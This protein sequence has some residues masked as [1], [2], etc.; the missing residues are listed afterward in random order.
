LYL[1]NKNYLIWIDA[2][3]KWPEVVE[4]SKMNSVH[5][6]EKL[7]EI[8]GRFGL[9]NKIISDNGPQ[10]RASAFI[11][12][13]KQNGIV[14]YTS[15]SFHPV[16][17]G[18]AENAVKSFKIGIQ[19][20]LKDKKNKDVTVST[21]INRYLFMYRNSPH[22]TTNECPA[23]LMFGRKLKTRLDFLKYSKI[24]SNTEIYKNKKFRKE[25]FKEGDIVYARDF[26]NPN[27]K[28][29]EKAVIEEVL[30]NRNYIVRLEDKELVWRRHIDHIIKL[31]EFIKYGYKKDY[32]KE[33]LEEVKE[34]EL[35]LEIKKSSEKVIEKEKQNITAEFGVNDKL[36]LAEIKQ[37]DVRPLRNKKSPKR[38]DL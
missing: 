7:R 4:M 35:E 28:N 1:N 17:N 2:F 33:I 3:K 24:K 12:F 37:K 26:S 27:K 9:P 29:W 32:E 30:G 21:L 6:I 5:L 8:F 13:C 25:V 36:K 15:P 16:T 20:A 11:E 23:K 14:F 34:N 38:L 22:W 18:A 10:F 19:K 31:E